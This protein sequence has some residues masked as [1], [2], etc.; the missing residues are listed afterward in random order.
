MAVVG[1][2]AVVLA[3]LGL[4]DL[5]IERLRVLG[6]IILRLKLDSASIS[7]FIRTNCVSVN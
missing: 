6:E 4:G 1:L 5:D 7:Y 3:A 2:P